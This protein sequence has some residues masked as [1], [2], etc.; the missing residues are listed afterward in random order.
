MKVLEL[1]IWSFKN[2]IK[3]QAVSFKIKLL[4]V[5]L[6]AKTFNRIFA[7]VSLNL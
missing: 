1:S 2:Q 7:S 3:L 4:L 5:N 6:S